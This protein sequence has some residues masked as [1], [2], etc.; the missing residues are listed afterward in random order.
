MVITLMDR[1]RRTKTSKVSSGKEPK[2]VVNIRRG[3]AVSPGQIH[4][5]EKFWRNLISETRRE[6]DNAE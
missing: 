6:N 3:V 2:V 5:W 1:I 4:I